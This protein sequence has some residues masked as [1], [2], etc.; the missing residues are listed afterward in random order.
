MAQG[1]TVD[2]RFDTFRVSS[3]EWDGECVPD[4]GFWANTVTVCSI[5]GEKDGIEAYMSKCR[6]GFPRRNPGWQRLDQIE[7]FY[8]KSFRV[9]CFV[10][11]QKRNTVL[12]VDTMEP[13][14]M[15]YLQVSILA[16]LPWFF[17]KSKGITNE[18]MELIY[19]LRET[20]P[21]K[22]IIALNRLAQKYNFRESRI[23]QLLQGFETQV[24]T[25]QIA[26]VESTN[27][28]LLDQIRELN[29]RIATKM[30]Q[31][32]QNNTFLLGLRQKVAMSNGESE[33]MDYFLCNNALVLESVDNGRLYFEVKGYLEYFNP[34]MAESILGNDHSF[35]YCQDGVSH[36]IVSCEKM[37]RLM[38]EIFV[39][40]S[41]RLKIRVCAA[42]TFNIGGSVSAR[43]SHRFSAD[44]RGYLPN[45]HIDIYRCIGDY[46]R[47]INTM[48][49][50]ND[51]IGA[52][53]Q[54]IASAKSLN[55]SD[56]TVMNAFFKT[57]WS[58]DTSLNTCIEL[59]NG[60]VVNPAG[61]IKWL[62]EQDEKEEQSE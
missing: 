7:A 54:C 61:A 19:S 46:T 3:P 55:W 11:E 62:E 37:R 33:I 36:S 32:N 48:L 6:D 17:D 52:I 10:N 58:S 26:Q 5:A 21:D 23:R 34:E 27:R 59:P 30:A 35:V 40:E 2:L 50:E 18:E 44:C 8:K 42:Y 39:S 13:R 31:L 51:Y 25:K 1:D 14:R 24:E 45:P 47:T 15:H 20:T 53:E 43:D 12:L 28:D 57:M 16:F 4:Q 22:Y 41:P 29:E 60:D 49:M 9:L 56:S 38:T